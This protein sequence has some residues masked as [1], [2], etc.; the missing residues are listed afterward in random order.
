MFLSLGVRLEVNIEAFNAVETVGNLT[1][2]R[3]APMVI[4]TEAGY[5][6]IYVPAVSGESIANAYQRNLVELA[7]QLYQE[8]PLTIWDLRHEFSKFMDDKHLVPDLIKI[9]N[10]AKDKKSRKKVNE[11]NVA[12]IK[13][14]FEKIAILK[15]LVADVG[16]FLYTGNIPVKR[17]SKVYFSYLLPTYDT[18]ETMAIEAQFHARHMPAETIASEIKDDKEA[19][20]EVEAEGKE[21]QRGEKK[22]RKTQAQMIYYVEVAS[23]VYGLTVALDIAGIGRTSL[24]RVENAVNQEERCKRIKT[25][26]GALASLF[27]GNGFG[28]KLSRFT[29]IKRVISA[30]AILSDPI[31]FMVTPSQYS[32]YI[33]DTIKRAT[34]Y[35]NV[36]IKLGLKPKVIAITLGK[37]LG[38]TQCVQVINTNTVEKLFLEIIEKVEESMNLEPQNTQ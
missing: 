11:D 20:Q 4:P 5:R 26:L 28:A 3:R 12:E 23:A 31:A 9:I 7:K 8:P 30:V 35:C 38:A 16:G 22:Q 21:E 34:E 32:N 15:S 1:K 2:H 14:N 29:P 17:T 37:Q 36:M 18:L 25:A 10:E 13:H 33:E 24:V 6:L 19:E 27:S